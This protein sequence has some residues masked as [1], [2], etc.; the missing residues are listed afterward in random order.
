MKTVLAFDVYGT[1]IDTAGVVSELRKTVGD[2]APEFSQVWRDKQ[3]EYSF[4]RALMQRY[5]DFS[6]CIRESLDFTCAYLRLPLTQKDKGALL[7]AYGVLPLFGDVDESLA[8]LAAAQIDMFAFSNGSHAAVDQ[9][10]RTAGIADRFV[11][12][13]SVEEVQTFKPNPAVYHHFLKR[14][15]VDGKNA[16]LISGNPFDVIGAVSAGMQAAWVRRST[17]ATFDTWGIEPTITVASL[18]ELKAAITSRR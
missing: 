10:L 4:R 18:A 3:L 15:E 1:L 6:V 11:D 13:V 7:S 9:L 16:W 14:A 2:R 12:I 8:E 5:E 17:D